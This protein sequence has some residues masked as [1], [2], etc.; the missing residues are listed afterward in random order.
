MIFEVIAAVMFVTNPHATF[1]LG[2]LAFSVG[3]TV[4]AFILTVR[5]ATA[6]PRAVAEA[7]E[8]NA[9]PGEGLMAPKRQGP[10]AVTEWT[11]LPDGSYLPTDPRITKPP[12][13][14]RP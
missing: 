11:Q 1:V 14:P 3:L 6:G 5:A 2:V 9:V 13:K 4:T 7:I 10:G 12:R 8:R